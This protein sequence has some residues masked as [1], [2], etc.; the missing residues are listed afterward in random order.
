MVFSPSL[1]PCCAADGPP[2]PRFH[3]H[4]RDETTGGVHKCRGPKGSPVSAG[5]P[6][7]SHRLYATMVAYID[8][9][10]AGITRLVGNAQKFSTVTSCRC[11]SALQNRIYCAP[12]VSALARRRSAQRTAANTCTDWVGA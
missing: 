10:V 11:L 5:L 9:G 4:H 6:E 2:P 1:A 3:G 12:T 8:C 7:R